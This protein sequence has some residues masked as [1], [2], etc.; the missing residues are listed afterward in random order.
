MTM[1]ALSPLTEARGRQ[2]GLD[3]PD[4][5]PSTRLCN[6]PKSQPRFE[7]LTPPPNFSPFCFIL[8]PNPTPRSPYHLHILK[9]I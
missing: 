7:T 8:F 5:C 4:S 1:A 9:V 2:Q 3:S 6:I